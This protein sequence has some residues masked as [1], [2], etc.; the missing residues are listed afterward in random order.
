[1]NFALV[2]SEFRRHKARTVFTILSVTVA[3]AIFL[4]LATL[5]NGFAGLVSY[6]RA[7]RVDVWSDGFGRLP[8]SY[9]A[10]IAPVA[11]I[12]ALAYQIGLF[13][14]FRDPKNSVF[15]AGVPFEQYMHVYPE[16]SVSN[17]GW[18]AMLADR[19]CTIVGAPLAGKM[20]WRVGD[21]IPIS[22]GPAQKDGGTTWYFHLC[23][24]FRSTLP[25][26]FMQTLVAHYN[27]LNEGT[28]DA[29]ARDQ[30]DQ[31]FLMT[32][33]AADVSKVAHAIENIFAN[34]Q[35]SAIALPDAL[36]YL[37]VVKSF[38]DIG[39]IITW[40]GLAVFLSMLLVT[41]N[42]LSNSVRERLN[43][44][45]VMRVLGFSRRRLAWQVLRESGWIVGVGA[46][47]GLVLGW[48]LCVMMTPFIGNVLPY[49]VVNAQA[50][51]VA[52]LLAAVFSVLTGM[53]PAQRVTALPVADTLRRI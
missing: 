42:A 36:L 32:D 51:V 50:V 11:G 33:N 24:I 34:T 38:G 40:V 35:P 29:G 20:G 47:L 44:F 23:G 27:Y 17:A 30:V 22:G 21:T 53:L 18:R 13:G 10:K 49:F 45:A 14:H 6:G 4:V 7:Q 1:M 16:L 41:G 43:E 48:R 8:I 3:F 26:S 19:R 25:D 46:V 28:A 12:K 37:S 2:W 15:V 39:A 31:I 52:V 5:Y 9:A